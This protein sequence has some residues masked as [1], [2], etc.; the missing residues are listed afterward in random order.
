MEEPGDRAASPAQRTGSARLLD[1]LFLLARSCH[2]PAD[3]T[4]L[5]EGI[6]DCL[7]SLCGAE[8]GFIL[9]SPGI[10]PR[11]L[12]EV[13]ERAGPG[14][15]LPCV[16]RRVDYQGSDLFSRSVAKRVLAG[17]K[18][19]LIADA[20][21]DRKFK[22]Q[23]SVLAAHI[24]SVLAAPLLLDGSPVGVIY[25]DSINAGASFTDEDLRLLEAAA[26]HVVAALANARERDRLTS[27]AAHLQ[28]V[29]EQE[30]TREYG[31]RS[32][33]G[34][35]PA[36]RKILEA[37]QLV[38][39]Q[40]TT[41]LILGESGT[42]KEL[43]A[44]A[45][46][47]LSGRKAG[48]FVAVNCMALSAGV[49]ESELFGHEKGTFSG[50][51][52][53]NVGRFEMADQGTVFLDEIGE[54]DVA[55]Q[56]KLLRVLQEKVVERVGSGR[57]RPVNVRLVC[58]TNADLDRAVKVGTFRSDLYYRIAVFPLRLPP[59]RERREDIAPLVEHF[60]RH[61]QRRMGKPISGIEPDALGLI[62]RH[63]WPG[64]IREL[65]N[66]I[67]H[68]FV[69]EQGSRISAASLPF[70]ASRAPA[71]AAMA[72]PAPAPSELPVPSLAAAREA[73]ERRFIVDCLQRHGGN[74]TK[75]AQELD[76]PRSTVYRKLEA[77]GL[78][79]AG[80]G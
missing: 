70:L 21:T 4:A 7:L 30:V 9:L 74:I 72:G 15:L 77:W 43:V 31:S 50:A 53:R 64:N 57:P 80:R 52:G 35:S 36:M 45:L 38:A 29:V 69:L 8:R 14:Q 24:R 5:M 42:G 20:S 66:V 27:R 17:G 47:D 32:I 55:V 79:P 48:P 68:A 46:H 6:M 78:L 54:L 59:L 41:T 23:E 1:A 75:A 61:F 39:R 71:P 67:E 56:V 76:V 25:L 19:L 13:V 22:D 11:A 65:R 40:D 12:G 49:L 73:F 28:A 10:A 16:S 2:A 26:E 63:S 37:V 44:R 60:I 3:S 51:T 62:E 18:A 58:A 34:D 33:V